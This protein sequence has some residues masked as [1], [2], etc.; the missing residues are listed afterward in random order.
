MKKLIFVI[1]IVFIS[2][3]SCND[4]IQETMNDKDFEQGKFNSSQWGE[5]RFKK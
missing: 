5:S 1:I 4:M 2:I 3:T